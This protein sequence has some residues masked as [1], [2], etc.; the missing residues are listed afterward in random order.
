[1]CSGCEWHSVKLGSQMAGTL[2]LDQKM[3]SLRIQKGGGPHSCFSTLCLKGE[4]S[5]WN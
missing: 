5:L 2:S 4:Y 3:N 1:M